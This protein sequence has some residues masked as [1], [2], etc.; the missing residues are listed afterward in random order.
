MMAISR[1]YVLVK[2]GVLGARQVPRWGHQGV[3]R[4]TTGGVGGVTSFGW[5]CI[6]D[7]HALL[8]LLQVVMARKARCCSR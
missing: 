5:G 1:G 8:S 4:H 6:A 2:Q 3:G 7:T